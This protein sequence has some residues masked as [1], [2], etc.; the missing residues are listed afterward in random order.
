MK[1]EKVMLIEFGDN[2]SKSALSAAKARAEA[3]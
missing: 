1:E 2:F 3:A